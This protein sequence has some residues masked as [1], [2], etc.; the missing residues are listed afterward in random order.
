MSQKREWDE[1]RSPQWKYL[2]GKES[3]RK[4]RERKDNSI[5][6]VFLNNDEDEQLLYPLGKE[7]QKRAPTKAESRKNKLKISQLLK[8]EHENSK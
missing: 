5:Q 3:K 7:Y 2:L 6:S 4:R 8:Q 1:S